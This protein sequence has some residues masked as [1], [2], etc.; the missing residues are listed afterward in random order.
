MG[1]G[2][3]VVARLIESLDFNWFDFSIDSFVRFVAHRQRRAVLL[4]PWAFDA[5]ITAAWVRGQKHDFIFFR[6]SAPPVLQTH[7]ILH[8]LGHLLLSHRGISMD[9]ADIAQV[10]QSLASQKSSVTD[11]LE[12]QQ[13]EDFAQ[14]VSLRIRQAKR[15]HREGPGTTIDALRPYAESGF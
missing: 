14:L 3:E 11:G 6:E 5:A 9:D 8:E 10:L 7:G 13:A 4:F 12:E 2:S 1:R 15:H